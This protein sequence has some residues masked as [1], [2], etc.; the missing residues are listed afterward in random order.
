MT[1]PIF[2]DREDAGRLLGERLKDLTLSRP[3]VLAIPR[4]G[5]EVG[6]QIAHALG[7]E[8][9]V[10][11][12][13]KLRAPGQP[14][15]ALG[16]VSESGDVHLDHDTMAMSEAAMRYLEDER[17]RQMAEIARRAGLFRAVRPGA[18]VAGRS[19]IITDDGIATGSTMIAALRTVRAR[20]PLELIVAVPVAP[21]DR[22]AE[23]RR[24][25]D[26]VV[27]LSVP[28]SFWAVGQFYRD[29]SEVSDERVVQLLGEHLRARSVHAAER[30][31][32]P[33]RGVPSQT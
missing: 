6:A 15:L 22:L 32:T 2:E 3:L 25:C 11:L 30:P 27:C 33:G 24:L 20:G 16:A 21:P 26:R 14:E 7:A 5:I 4:G 18:D 1:H 28:D 31:A 8:L 10:V 13:R 9:D 29:F 17:T 19:V 23:I 12:S